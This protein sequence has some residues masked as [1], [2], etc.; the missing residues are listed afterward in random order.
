MA[1][2]P[3]PTAK[4]TAPPLPQ[5]KEPEGQKGHRDINRDLTDRESEREALREERAQRLSEAEPYINEQ[6]QRSRE[7]EMMGVETWKAS[8]DQRP[9]EEQPIL[10]RNAIAG[11][12]VLN[13]PVEG[14]RQVPGV[15]HP[16][17]PTPDRAPVRNPDGSVPTRA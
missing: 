16:T 10:V 9:E 1:T 7:I 13:T 17:T 6:M 14:R 15:S 2:T 3:Q 11:G 4:P 5:S 8:Q 12:D